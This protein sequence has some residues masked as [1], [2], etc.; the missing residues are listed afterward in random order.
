MH[1]NS[2]KYLHI[3]QLLEYPCIPF[4][5]H[6]NFSW[7]S[8]MSALSQTGTESRWLSSCQAQDDNTHV[9]T[10]NCLSSNLG[11]VHGCTHTHSSVISFSDHGHVEDNHAGHGSDCLACTHITQEDLG[12]LPKRSVIWCIINKLVNFYFLQ[13]LKTKKSDRHFQVYKWFITYTRI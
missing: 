7:I 8:F 6:G 1:T 10:C 4:N 12:I 5:L 11:Q 9:C 2:K 3:S 13:W